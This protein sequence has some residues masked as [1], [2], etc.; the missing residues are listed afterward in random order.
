MAELSDEIGPRVAGTPAEAR[1]A[2]RIADWFQGLGYEPAVRSFALED[3]DPSRASANVIA[4]KLGTS[5]AR[6]SSAPTTTR[7]RR[8]AGRSTTPAASPS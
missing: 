7:S 2:G 1:A 4:V 6:S 8:A 5:V 3:G